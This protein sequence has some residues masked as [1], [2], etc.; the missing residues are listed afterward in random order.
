MP[1][2]REP[3]SKYLLL[4]PDHFG[5]AIVTPHRPSTQYLIDCWGAKRRAMLSETR[6]DVL[7]NYDASIYESYVNTKKNKK[8][9]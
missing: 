9:W 3:V 1:K 7:G 8:D 5:N 2:K 4:W 6:D